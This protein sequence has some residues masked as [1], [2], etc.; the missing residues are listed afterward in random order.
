M[1]HE[2][3]EIKK[4]VQEDRKKKAEATE[5]GNNVEVMD[6]VNDDIEVN[7]DEHKETETLIQDEFDYEE[8]GSEVNGQSVKAAKEGS[9]R[10][11]NYEELRSNYIKER[12]KIFQASG[13]MKA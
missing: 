9:T 3:Q 13:L 11:N 10:S 2:L 8:S 12:M 5:Q 6:V 4:L 7:N 1:K